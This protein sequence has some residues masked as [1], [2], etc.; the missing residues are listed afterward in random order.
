MYA[1]VNDT[2]R[3][4]TAV[5][6]SLILFIGVCA[7]SL[8]FLKRS[9]YP[10]FKVLCDSNHAGK[11]ITCCCAFPCGRNILVIGIGLH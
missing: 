2:A 4:V 5:I 9:S 8:A 1:D 7:I 10:P 6:T 11:T 3:T